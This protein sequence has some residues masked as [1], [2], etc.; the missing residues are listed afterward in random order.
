MKRICL[1]LLT[2][3][4]LAGCATSV[5][6]VNYTDEKFLPKPQ[7]YFITIYHDSQHPPSIQ[8]Y[9]V[10]GRVEVSGYISDG[11]NPDTLTDQ[12]KTIA[13]KKGADAIINAKTE[14]ANY[15]GVYVA[16]GYI[17]YHR[18]YRSYHPTEYIPYSNTLL[19]FRGELIVF[20]SH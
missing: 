14:S 13:R 3:L 15:S 6:Y 18:C 10:I 2:I 17:A 5:R 9:S 16:S 1:L 7:Y 19:T 11:V 12:A 8:P 4:S 20:S